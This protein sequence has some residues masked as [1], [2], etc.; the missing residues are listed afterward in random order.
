MTQCFLVEQTGARKITSSTAWGTC[1]KD[2]WAAYG[3][4]QH[5]ATV[6]TFEGSKEDADRA[7]NDRER[8]WEPFH[9]VCK[10]CGE[11]GG[12]RMP[13]STGMHPMWVRRDTGE[14]KDHVRDFGVGA[15]YYADWEHSDRTDTEGRLLWGFDWDN[16]YE[17]P[18]HVIT[19][20]G[21]WNIDARASNCTMKNDRF[22]RCWVRH[23]LPPDV[24]V[25]KIGFTCGAG[26]GSIIC[27]GYHG[28]L[29]NGKLTVTL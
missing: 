23:G 29:H 24:H 6:T 4:P 2:P 17:P 20:G 14:I 22:H 1:A 3:K 19:P 11:D 26:A 18:L 9:A 12:V 27:G 13:E 28:F 25:D 7:Y 10:H 16:L 15:L 21:E 5:R 8:R